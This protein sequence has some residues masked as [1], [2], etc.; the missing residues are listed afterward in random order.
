LR[1]SFPN[2]RVFFTDEISRFETK[3]PVIS[4]ED[5][6]AVRRAGRI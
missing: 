3:G 5:D 6:I 1:K 4:R 2:I